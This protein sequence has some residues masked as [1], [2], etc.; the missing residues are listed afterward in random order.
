[1]TEALRKM[2]EA[3]LDELRRQG[4]EG[5]KGP[6]IDARQ[7]HPSDT[8][9]DMARDV[10][11]DG[12]VNLEKVARAGLNALHGVDPASNDPIPRWAFDRM[13]EERAKFLGVE[14][15]PANVDVFMANST[16]WQGYHAFAAYIARVERPQIEP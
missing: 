14:P 12:R 10:G 5:P 2:V 8:F 6:Y 3:M 15:N 1:M 9:E 7:D 4:E 16:G 11:I 13:E